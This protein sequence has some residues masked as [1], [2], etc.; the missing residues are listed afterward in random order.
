[1]T[2]LP[3]ILAAAAFLLFYFYFRLRERLVF[4]RI[5]AML[6][7][8]IAGD[9][10]ERE[11]SESALSSVE[12]KLSSFLAATSISA[13]QI[14]KEQ[15]NMKTLLSDISHQTKTPIAN[16]LLYCQLLEEQPLPDS[17]QTA[18]RALH[19]QTEKLNFLIGSLIKLSRL[20]AGIISV[21]PQIQSIEPILQ[22]VCRQIAPKAAQKSISVLL[23]PSSQT[24]YFDAKWTEEALY[25]LVDNAVKYTPSG[26][27][28][29]IRV[30]AYELFPR[31]EVQD[32]GIC[33]SEEEQSK[34]LPLQRRRCSRGRWGGSISDAGNHRR[35]GRLLYS[36]VQPVSR[37]YIFFVSSPLLSIGRRIWFYVLYLGQ[38]LPII[39]LVLY[40][41]TPN[42]TTGGT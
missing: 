37:L 23:E 1:M 35:S 27:S 3:W 26:G 39:G 9:F 41:A 17:C 5:S 22:S 18:V 7:R 15:Q 28:V 30:I 12:A 34:I 20:E 31:I 36:P 19:T 8:A 29:W 21:H 33:I 14:K 4:H 16:L 13:A 40:G 25:N 42:H 10:E 11:F 2:V 24:A 32:T 38:K 6:D